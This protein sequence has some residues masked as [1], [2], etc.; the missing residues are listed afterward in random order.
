MLNKKGCGDFHSRMC[1]TIPANSPIYSYIRLLSAMPFYLLLSTLARLA[2]G[3][4]SKEDDPTLYS[5]EIHPKDW[6]PRFK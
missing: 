5:I 2:D 4:G 3:F 6:F 1:P